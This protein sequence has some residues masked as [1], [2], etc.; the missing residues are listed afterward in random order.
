MHP[1]ATSTLDHPARPWRLLLIAGLAAGLSAL[2]PHA[3]AQDSK[4]PDEQPVDEQ[5]IT[6]AVRPG[7]GAPGRVSRPGQPGVTTTPPSAEPLADDEIQLPEMSEP[8]DI[9]LLLKYVIDTL[10][11]NMNIDPGLTGTVALNAPMKIKRENLLAVVNALLEQ[12]GHTLTHDTLLDFYEVVPLDKVGISFDNKLATT[13]IIDTPNVKPSGLQNLISIQFGGQPGQNPPDL[14]LSYVD[15]IGFIMVTGSPRKVQAVADLVQQVLERRSKQ[16]RVALDLKY[17]SASAAKKRLLEMAGANKQVQPGMEGNPNS[18]FNTSKLDNLEDRLVVSPQGNSIIFRGLPEEVEEVKSLIAD[19]D[20]PNLLDAVRYF[21]GTA[22][23]QIADLASNRG[24]GESAKFDPN[25]PQFTV[26]PDG[27]VAPAEQITGGSVIVVDEA[28]GY[29]VYY[30]TPEQQSQMDELVKQFKPE[31]E[32]PVLVVYKL[33]NSDAED[34]ATVIQ[35]LLQNQTPTGTG[36]LL[37]NGTTPGGNTPNNRMNQQPPGEDGQDPQQPAPEG[38]NTFTGGDGVF[39]I[40]DK[41]NNQIVVKA[42]AKQQEE[43][44]HLIQKLDLRRPQVFLQAQIVAVTASDEIQLTV[45]SQLVGQNG[46]I[47]TNFGLSTIPS[48][49]GDIKIPKVIPLSLSGFTAALIDSDQVPIVI[50]A[51]RN[52]VNARVVATPQIL[53]D[54]NEE[55][56]IASVEAQPITETTISTGNPNTV[57]QNGDVQAGPK[58]KVTPH[59]SEG[60]YVRLEY[61]IELSAF[62]GPASAPGIAPPQQINTIDSKSVTVPNDMTIV[63][64]GLTFETLRDAKLR[65]PLLGDIPL[66]GALFGSTQHKNSKTTLYVF[67]T[68]RIMRDPN[69]IDLALISKG[70]QA[71]ALLNPDIP[72]LQPQIIDTFA[73]PALSSTAGTTDNGNH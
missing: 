11:I 24:L 5:P 14:K 48:G 53:V 68:P 64:G 58:L 46:A 37:P 3:R 60:G 21:A 22:T 9:Q 65:I 62:T 45:E 63:V 57:T 10:H 73:P 35:G 34:V 31:N 72:E 15:D 33:A 70:P 17:I 28:R 20:R 44:D 66:V 43:F 61:S 38:Q 16:E 56:N 29:L 49:G 8:M 71:E 40:A 39:V 42:P 47:N 6:P 32:V 69:F 27:S 52:K 2:A 59:I 36:A 23:S 50:N 18:Q 25:N 55:A 7:Q 26:R 51:L 54:D 41:A 30:G 12:R 1:T 13:R 4:T 19:V 67:L